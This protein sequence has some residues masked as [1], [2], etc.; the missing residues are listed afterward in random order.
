MA[1]RLFIKRF[2]RPPVDR[3]GNRYYADKLRENQREIE[4]D[5]ERLRRV[6]SSSEARAT[7]VE[8]LRTYDDRLAQLEAIVE[9]GIEH[10][11]RLAE[12]S[13]A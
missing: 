3:P 1:T 2:R 8:Q 10:R 12:N 9:A 4:R 5:I 11:K 7:E 6:V 13:A